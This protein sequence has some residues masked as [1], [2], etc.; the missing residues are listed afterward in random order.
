MKNQFT[1]S[2]YHDGLILGL[3]EAILACLDAETGALLWKGGRYGYG[4]VM[5]VGGHL[6]V[7]TE[8]GELVLVRPDRKAHVELAKFPAIDG[9]SWNHPAMADGLLLVRNI[10]EMAAFDLRPR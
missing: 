9:K 10:G 3:D 7:L 2:V 8:G 1:S 5:L 4:Q 6:I